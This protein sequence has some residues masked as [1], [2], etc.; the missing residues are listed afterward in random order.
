ME[1][2]TSCESRVGGATVNT[3]KE[4][5]TTDLQT[6]DTRNQPGESNQSIRVIEYQGN[7]SIRVTEY[8]GNE[9]PSIK[10]S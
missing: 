5:K 7:Q 10:G 8:Q 6:R 2:I 1:G 4:K 3:T 9:A